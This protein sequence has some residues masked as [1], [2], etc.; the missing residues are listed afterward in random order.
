[1]L[2]MSQINSIWIWKCLHNASNWPITDIKNLIV[3][4]CKINFKNSLNAYFHSAVPVYG[5]NSH[6]P[7]Q[8]H[9]PLLYPLYMQSSF[10]Q[11]QSPPSRGKKNVGLPFEYRLECSYQL[12]CPSSV[13]KAGC[14]FSNPLKWKRFSAPISIYC[15]LCTLLCPCSC[16]AA[17]AKE[18]LFA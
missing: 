18:L 2:W 15:M 10:T 8:E 17:D 11:T 7:L 14:V 4:L 16:Q 6:E 9:F 3:I 12:L 5:A 1:M 13:L